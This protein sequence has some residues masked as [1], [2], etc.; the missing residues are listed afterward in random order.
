M[1]DTPEGDENFP[2]KFMN[3]SLF[4]EMIDTLKGDENCNHVFNTSFMPIVEMIATPE[5]D[6]NCYK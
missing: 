3:C 6:E 1:I 5:G 4:V 2:A